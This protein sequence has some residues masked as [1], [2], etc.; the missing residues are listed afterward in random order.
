MVPEP[1]HLRKS[2]ISSEMFLDADCLPKSEFEC[3][4]EAPSEMTLHA[5]TAP[6]HHHHHAIN[7]YPIPELKVTVDDDCLPKG[8]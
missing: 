2:S 1:E 6:H 3:L 8:I 4:P 5:P 7:I